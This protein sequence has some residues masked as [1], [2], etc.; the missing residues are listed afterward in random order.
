MRTNGRRTRQRSSS[1]S[2]GV[3]D[4]LEVL[5]ADMGVHFGRLCATDLGG[6]AA[7]VS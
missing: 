3:D 1:A 5:G 6:L 7:G 4:A 2:K